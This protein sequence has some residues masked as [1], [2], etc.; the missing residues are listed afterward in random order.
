MAKQLNWYG[1]E[2]TYGP[3]DTDWNYQPNTEDDER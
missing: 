3:D 2:P 1:M